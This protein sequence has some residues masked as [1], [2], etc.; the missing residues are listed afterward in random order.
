MEDESLNGIYHFEDA[1]RMAEDMEQDLI[2]I[3]DSPDMPICRI[4]EYSKFR[5][6]QRKKEKEMAKNQHVIQMKEIRFGPNT[7]EH[8]FNFKLR[9]AEKFLEEGNKVRAYVQFRGRN[10]VY[11]ERGQKML[12]E[13]A[14]ALEEKAKVEMLPKM[15][16][17][18]M[19]MIL[20]PKAAKKK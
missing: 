4:M 5:Y 3:A 19:Y 15:E 12:L 13:F 2:Q 1:I 8:D 6:L 10:I 11:K 18:R 17:R 7:D 9:H 20:S 14:Q 16:G